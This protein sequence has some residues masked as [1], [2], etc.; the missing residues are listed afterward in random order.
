[1]LSALAVVLWYGVVELE[2]GAVVE[3][4]YTTAVDDVYGAVVGAA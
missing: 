4:E 1:M 2:Y 3:D